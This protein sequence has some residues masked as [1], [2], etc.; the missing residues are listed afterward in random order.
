MD[1]LGQDD[2][3]THKHMKMITETTYVGKNRE[4]GNKKSRDMVADMKD[5]LQKLLIN[6][7][8]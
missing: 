7:V 2:K 1:P 3:E 8:R 5:N 6:T 4:N